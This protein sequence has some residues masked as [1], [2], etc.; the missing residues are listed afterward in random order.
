M[1]LEAFPAA[2]GGYH[3]QSLLML[4]AASDVTVTPL[5]SSLL[6]VSCMLL[7]LVE[8]IPDLEGKEAEMAQ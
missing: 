2:E 1:C 4:R 6:P 8:C 3:R 5:S 7:S